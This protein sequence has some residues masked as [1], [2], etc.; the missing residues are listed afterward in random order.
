MKYIISEFFRSCY[1]IQCG[2][3]PQEIRL[4]SILS[5]TYI[6]TIDVLHSLTQAYCIPILVNAVESMSLKSIR[7]VPD[8]R[9]DSGFL[10]FAS[11]VQSMTLDCICIHI[12]IVT[13][14]FCTDVS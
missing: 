4:N 12:F 10:K 5:K 6:K 3:L 2:E 14:S 8:I 13:G 1:E 7:D 11:D 9:L